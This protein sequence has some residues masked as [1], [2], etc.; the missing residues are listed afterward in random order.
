MILWI[1]RLHKSL[2]SSHFCQI[3]GREVF[4]IFNWLNRNTI[5]NLESD[6]EVVEQKDSQQNM[7]RIYNCQ[8]FDSCVYNIT[9]FKWYRNIFPSGSGK[10]GNSA[11]VVPVGGFIMAESISISQMSLGSFFN[12]FSVVN[13]EVIPMINGVG[14][15]KSYEKM[16]RT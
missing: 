12:F 13:S 15:S 3:F 10:L 6:H 4:E 16:N 8:Y 9:C 5:Q 11:T 1:D 2:V 7:Q 14:A